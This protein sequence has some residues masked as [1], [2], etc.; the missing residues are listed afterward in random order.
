MNNELD[1]QVVN[2]AKAIRQSESGGNFAAKGKSGEHGGYQFTPDTWNA[3]A[4][5]YGI[6]NKLEQATPEEQNAVAYNRIKDWKDKGHDV[7]QIASMWNAGEGEPD[8]YTGKFGS[9]TPTHKAGDPSIGVNKFGAKYDVPAYAESVSKAY[10]ALKNGQDIQ[11]DPNNPSSVPQDASQGGHSRFDE[12]GANTVNIPSQG[13]IS[14]EFSQAGQDFSSGNY[15]GAAG[16]GLSGAIRGIG[17]ILTLGGSEQLGE[18]LGTKIAQLGPNGKFVND[19]NDSTGQILGGGSKVAGAIG[20]LAAVGAGS[21]LLSKFMSPVRGSVLEGTLE[22]F[23]MNLPEFESLSKV[24]KLNFLGEAAKSAPLGEARELAK[25]ISYLD[26]VKGKTLL[27]SL[28][29]AGSGA[30]LGAGNGLFNWI[31][32]KV[33]DVGHEAL[34]GQ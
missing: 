19:S 18:G 4:P 23:N 24:E 27:T 31:K 33:A 13:G 10:L 26:P 9:T 5:K 34:T 11:V 15:L 29:I 1:P 8:A 6:T 21:G 20:S 14:S 2:L 16:H 3:V 30:L 17:N 25:M 22:R 7:T 32:G 28:K 12:T